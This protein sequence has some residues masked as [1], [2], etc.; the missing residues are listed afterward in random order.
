M[1]N[2]LYILFLIFLTSACV[3]LDDEPAISA[4]PLVIEGWIEEGESPI[5]I[6]THAIDLTQPVDTFDNLVEKWGRVSVFDGDTRYVLTGRINKDYMPSFIFTSTRLKGKVGHTYRLL[7]ETESD[8]VDA[9]ATMLPKA[10]LLPL[11]IKKAEDRDSAYYVQAQ[12][13][14]IDRNGYYKL[15]AKSEMTESRYFGSF[16]GTFAGNEYDDEKGVSVLKGIHSGY[17]DREKDHYY[18]PGDRVTVKLCTLEPLIYDFWR[19][20]DE[21][22]ML[23]ENLFFTFD[24][25]CRANINGA[26][27]YWAAY[28]MSIRTIRIPE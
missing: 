21:N 13:D 16:L 9:Y 12:I 24:G 8:T 25:N 19:T 7:V 18:S 10:N 14:N 23:S 15:F 22:V 26:L 11:T 5:V 28:G 2:A 17:S 20:Y 4:P 27:G 3:G 1:K 6:V